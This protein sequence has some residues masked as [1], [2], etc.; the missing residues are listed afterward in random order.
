MSNVVEALAQALKGTELFLVCS[1]SG[2]GMQRACIDNDQSTDDGD[3]TERVQQKQRRNAEPGNEHTTQ[4]RPQHTRHIDQRRVERDG[5]GQVFAA[6]H[7]TYECLPRGRIKRIGD[8]QH[9]HQDQNTPHLRRSRHH[10]QPHE[11]RLN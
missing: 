10:Q 4:S 2:Q 6:H 7:F 11:S 3:K 9:P 1:S 5:V 8:T